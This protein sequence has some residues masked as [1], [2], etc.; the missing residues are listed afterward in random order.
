MLDS[1][2]GTENQCRLMGLGD[3]QPLMIQCNMAKVAVERQRDVYEIMDD[4][5]LNGGE[6]IRCACFLLQIDK[7]LK[8]LVDTVGR[9]AE[10]I[11]T[12]RNIIPPLA[13]SLLRNLRERNP[14]EDV[15]IPNDRFLDFVA[16]LEPHFDFSQDTVDRAMTMS[17]DEPDSS[18]VGSGGH[19]Q[20]GEARTR[21]Q[22]Q[23]LGASL[24]PHH[25]GDNSYHPGL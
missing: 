11:D 2:V 16:T 5:G 22:S 1:L 20:I 7:M 18:A 14:Q 19:H 25:Q 12:V 10:A 17:A 4:V 3:D 23:Q 9:N 8:E 6:R 24:H 13:Q 21:R 15:G